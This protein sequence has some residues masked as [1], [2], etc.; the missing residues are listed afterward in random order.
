MTTPALDGARPWTRVAHHAGLLVAEKGAANGAGGAAAP[1]VLLHGFSGTHRAWDD[2]VPGLARG[3][4]VLA[5]DLP[6]HGQSNASDAACTIEG[7][8]AALDRVIEACAA[9]RPV[10][11]GY[12]MGG[13]L[14]L[15]HAI[16]R[17]GRIAALVLESV[18]PGLAD[19][20]AR[21]ARRAHDERLARSAIE[22]GI[23]SFVGRWERNPAI[24]PVRP[25]AASVVHAQRA[26]RLSCSPEGLAASLRGMGAGTMP[27]LGDRLATVD[28]PTLLV[29]GERD[30]KFCALARTMQAAMPRAHHEILPRCGHDV[31]LEAPAEL[32]AIVR[33]FIDAGG[34]A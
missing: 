26:M 7:A 12:S 34:I 33:R 17:P 15:Y 24:V 16:T 6:G 9:E 28:V 2:V 29:S 27:W 22:E 10:L 1:I 18:S 5:P 32:L 14:A 4:R 31:H 30:E 8:A 20:G 13:R 19:A 25:L 21:A 3:R 23:E 11:Y